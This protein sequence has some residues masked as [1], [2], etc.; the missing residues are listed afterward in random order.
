MC[1]QQM[2]RAT[3]MPCAMLCLQSLPASS[4]ASVTDAFF[5]LIKPIS[6]VMMK[7]TWQQCIS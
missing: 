5:I 1:L 2:E 3:C 4:K 7:D 6:D